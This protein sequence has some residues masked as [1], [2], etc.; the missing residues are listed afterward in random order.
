METTTPSLGE[1]GLKVKQLA[2]LRAER[3]AL[4]KHI[5]ELEKEL[6]PV[7]T[8]MLSEV[9]GR[10]V[11]AAPAVSPIGVQPG[12]AFMPHGGRPPPPGSGGGGILPPA[13]PDQAK[14]ILKNRVIAFLKNAPPGIGAGEIAQAMGENDLRVREV[15]FELRMDQQRQ[16]MTAPPEYDPVDPRELQMENQ[17][18]PNTSK[19]ANAPIPAIVQAARPGLRK[20]PVP[21]RGQPPGKPVPTPNDGLPPDEPMPF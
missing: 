16:Q 2:E 11:T 14:T 13:V 19:G 9:T 1:L 10:P 7:L 4:D 8:S 20:A 15:M 18:L 17:R 21:G 6:A 3:E 5:G 12:P